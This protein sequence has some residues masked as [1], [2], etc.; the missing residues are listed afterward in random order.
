M[1]EHVHLLVVPTCADPA[2]DRYLARVKQPFSKW[3]KQQ[4]STANSHRIKQLTVQERPGKTCI[5]FWQEGPGYDRNLMKPA[6]IEAAIE[7]IHMNPVRRR[8]VKRATDWKWSSASWYV[9]DPP[10]QHFPGLPVVHGLSPG[11]LDQ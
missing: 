11:T 7:Y 9:L 3:L 1:P 2:L 4:L 5:R 10:R 8:L 6:A